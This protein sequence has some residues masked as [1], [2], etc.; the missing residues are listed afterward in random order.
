LRTPG[1]G[2][3]FEKALWQV[4]VSAV[5]GIDEAGRG[6]LA[7]PVATAAVVFPDD[8]DLIYSLSGVRDSKQ[9]TPAQRNH[10]S[11]HIKNLAAAWGVGFASAEEIDL[12]GILPATR[13]AAV[14]ALDALGLV[15]NHLI[16]DYL[17]LPEC[18]LPQTSLVKGDQRS[19]SVAAASVLA[20][21]TRDA[22][23]VALDMQVPGYGFARH[24]GY[25]T[26]VHCAA[27]ESLGLSS[28]HRR[29]FHVHRGVNYA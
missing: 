21:T 1:P 8:D 19:L 7:G 13:L 28:V 29:T 25:G 26:A 23:M 9:M 17:F 15:P 10:W 12:L 27:L 22:F 11:V 18:P 4:G 6:A 24:K 14:R 5:A 3:T 16:L 20:K 2:L